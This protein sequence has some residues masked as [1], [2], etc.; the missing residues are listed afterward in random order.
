MSE[1]N[2]FVKNAASKERIVGHNKYQEEIQVLN[3]II[4]ELNNNIKVKDDE[5]SLFKNNVN[6]LYK[7]LQEKNMIS[8]S[9]ADKLKKT[10]ND[11]DDMIIKYNSLNIEYDQ[12]T[13]ENHI[14]YD[15]LN[16]EKTQLYEIITSNNKINEDLLSKYNELKGKYQD[17][18]LLLE[19]K[20]LDII[21]L[22]SINLDTVS[23]LE[24]YKD[25]NLKKQNEIETIKNA[26]DKSNNEIN[27][28][29][30]SASKTDAYLKMISKKYA[31]EK[32]VTSEDK[33]ED[34]TENTVIETVVNVALPQQSL[35]GDLHRSGRGVKLS[36]R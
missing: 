23:Q 31:Y 15:L 14:K 12:N 36:R 25:L 20:S 32:P 34:N 1:T 8:E 24:M 9:N 4:I 22:K 10:S 28:L 2:E 30:T 7:Q 5:I 11:L 18:L 13:N 35:R 19:Q 16:N 3:K 33:I 21:E 29:K 6:D 26:L 27:V 17:G